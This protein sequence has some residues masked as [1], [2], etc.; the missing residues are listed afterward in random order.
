MDGE[1]IMVVAL[2]RRH[3]AG[4]AA[5]TGLADTFAEPGAAARRGLRRATA[6]GTGIAQVITALLEPWFAGRTL[7]DV[8]RD[9][10]G[11]SGAVVEVPA[12]HRPGAMTAPWPPVP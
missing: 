9:L 12:L 5:V 11:S 10:A 8:E 6:T 4:L 1:R 3:F 7:A 2:T